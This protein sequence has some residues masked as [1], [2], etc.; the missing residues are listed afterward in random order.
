MAI[1]V[2]FLLVIAALSAYLNYRTGAHPTGSSDVVD[3]DAARIDHEL[4]AIIGVREP[5]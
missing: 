2:L 1:F 5:R 4:R 3:R